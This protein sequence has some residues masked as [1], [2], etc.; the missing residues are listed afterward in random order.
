MPGASSAAVF[1]SS[2][3]HRIWAAVDDDVG[4]ERVAHAGEEHVGTAADPLVVAHR[5]DELRLRTDMLPDDRVQRFEFGFISGVGD[6]ARHE[7][8]VEGLIGRVRVGVA[9]GG[10]EELAEP[11]GAF[12]RRVGDVR[13]GADG[14]ADRRNK[15]RERIVRFRLGLRSLGLGGLCFLG[16]RLAGKLSGLLGREGLRYLRGDRIGLPAGYEEQRQAEEHGRDAA[17]PPKERGRVEHGIPPG[18]MVRSGCHYT[19]SRPPRQGFSRIPLTRHA[20]LCYNTVAN[21]SASGCVS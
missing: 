13:V 18:C 5:G 4:I 16:D 17:Y 9:V 20:R 12:V 21:S 7:H 10:V 15:V 2:F 14:K 8:R 6:V 3:S 19:P 1:N 11:H